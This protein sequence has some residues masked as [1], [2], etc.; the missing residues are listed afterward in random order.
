VLGAGCSVFAV[1]TTSNQQPK[2]NY[3]LAITGK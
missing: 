3:A 1:A 2:T